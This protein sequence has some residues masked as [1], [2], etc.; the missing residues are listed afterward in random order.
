MAS[1][2]DVPAMVAAPDCTS[3]VEKAD[4][5][6]TPSMVAAPAR[7]DPPTADSA[8]DP[9]AVHTDTTVPV[10][11][12]TADIDPVPDI[13]AAPTISLSV[14]AATVATPAIVAAPAMTL[15]PAAAIDP[16]PAMLAAPVGD[17]LAPT[18]DIDPVPDILAAPP[19]FSSLK[20]TTRASELTTDPTPPH[21][22]DWAELAILYSVNKSTVAL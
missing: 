7:R 6:P 5:D 3:A 9:P 14:V 19:A 15:I 1:N 2:V 18:A 22:A 17:P 12:A 10:R 16:T 11:D 21:V 20:L 13:E 8:P 4:I